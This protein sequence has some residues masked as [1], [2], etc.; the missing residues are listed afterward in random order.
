MR[1]TSR[2][3][4]GVQWDNFFHFIGFALLFF[5]PSHSCAA[6][7]PEHGTSTDT[8]MLC[9]ACGHEVAFGTDTHFVPSR[10]ALSSRNDTSVGGRRIHI[11]LFENPQGLQFEVIVF[12]KADVIKHWPADSHFSWYPGF[13]WTVATCPRC[14]THLG[15]G[16]QPNSW[17]ETV[18]NKKFEESENTF[19]ALIAHRILREDFASSL[20]M[21]PKSFTS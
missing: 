13:S 6:D 9:R 5:H 12:K 2:L 11:Q 8:L 10:M 4:L 1:S 16:F 15:W 21:T 18:T 3:L 17:P 19:L 20:L 7:P 14:K